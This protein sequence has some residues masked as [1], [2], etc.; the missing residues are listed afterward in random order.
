MM[1]TL[2]QLHKLITRKKAEQLSLRQKVGYIADERE[3]RLEE[4]LMI[5]EEITTLFAEAE[6]E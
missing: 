5:L 1:P 4:Q 6:K 3:S 2:V